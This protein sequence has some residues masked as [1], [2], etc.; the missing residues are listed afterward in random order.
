VSIQ[1]GEHLGLPDGVADDT[2]SVD[3]RFPGGAYRANLYVYDP[4]GHI[5]WYALP[6]KS[7]AGGRFFTL[8]RAPGC[9]IVLADASVSARHACVVS[10]GEE[11]LLRDLESTNGTLVNDEPVRE[12][13]LRH[14]DVIRIGATDVRFLLSDRRSPVQV[15]LEFT[16]GPNAGKTLPTYAASATVGRL[17]CAVNLQGPGVAPQHVRIDAYGRDLAFVANLRSGNETLLNDQKVRGVTPIRSGDRLR[18]GPHELVVRI[19][20]E[21]GALDAIPRG[22]GTL[23]VGEAPS[24]RGQDPIAQMSS[25]QFRA[26]Q[27]RL[28]EPPP[29]HTLADT[30]PPAEML[31]SP[32]DPPDFTVRERPV[33]HPPLPAPPRHKVPAARPRK[34]RWLRWLALPAG[35][36]ALAGGAAL[37]P[38]PRTL[39]LAGVLAPA[40]EQTLQSPARGRVEKLYFRPGDKVV[41]GDPVAWVTDVEAQA[42]LDRL[43]AEVQSLEQRMGATTRI[44]EGEVPASLQRQI[45][46]AETALKNANQ[47]ERL[48]D[49]EFNRRQSDIAALEAARRATADARVRLEALR[50]EADGLRSR[51]HVVADSPDAA[52]LAR[53]EGLLQQRAALEA[54]LR[55]QVNAPAGGLLL[56]PADAPAPREGQS[57]TRGE[58]LYTIADVSSL[59]LRAQVPGKYLAAVEPGKAAVLT[60]DGFPDKRFPIELGGTSPAADADGNFTLDADVPAASLRPGQHVRV[61]LDLPDTNALSWLWERVAGG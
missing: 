34:R 51:R 42:E 40:A 16:D 54:R 41:A 60:P 47:A 28:S 18:V 29:E 21:P 59:R 27:V 31:L 15:V 14:G 37:V 20:D 33:V 2:S 46:D 32:T 44:V 50:R 7:F 6:P 35:L 58:P 43:G 55:V 23:L 39:S 9:D 25:D 61:A 48:R 49:E 10:D 13:A 19:V 1:S 38:V 8:G 3:V 5:S 45:E 52:L 11:L 36:G 24:L 4:R 56:A 17:N 57:V 53:L 26:L 22:K 12:V 30:Q